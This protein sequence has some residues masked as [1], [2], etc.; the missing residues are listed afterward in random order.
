MA[1][2]P[3]RGHAQQPRGLPDHHEVR[4]GVQEGHI[5]SGLDAGGLRAQGDRRGIDLAAPEGGGHA[6]QED[7]A[8]SQGVPGLAGAEAAVLQ[9]PVE[10]GHA[11]R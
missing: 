8:V 1:A 4:V 7:L 6:V 10:S 2:P 5:P 11:A 9:D 3:G